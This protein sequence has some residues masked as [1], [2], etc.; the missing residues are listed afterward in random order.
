MWPLLLVLAALGAGPESLPGP[1]RGVPREALL[2]IGE[3]GRDGVALGRELWVWDLGTGKKRI[4]AK[5][6]AEKWQSISLAPRTDGEVERALLVAPRRLLVVH[7]RTGRAIADWRVSGDGQRFAFWSPD[8]RKIGLVGWD[9]PALR[10]PPRRADEIPVLIIDAEV[11][12]VVSELRLP[13]AATLSGATFLRDSRT[14]VV[15]VGS[16]L[17][18]LGPGPSDARTIAIEH[19]RVIGATRDAIVVQR[20]GTFVL[21]DPASGAR[22]S[23]QG[24]V[25]APVELSGEARMLPGGRW[26]YVA[27]R[28]A[29][30]AC[31]LGRREVTPLDIATLGG[32]VF[33][34]TDGFVVVGKK[35]TRVDSTGGLPEAWRALRLC[36]R[37]T[38][39]SGDGAMVDL[40]HNRVYSGDFKRGEPEGQGMLR[41][42][43]GSVYVGTFARGKPHGPGRLISASGSERQVRAVEGEWATP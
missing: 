5:L 2:A 9:L 40:V 28:E 31:D 10:T 22:A 42:E 29:V 3:D 38:C 7:L 34:S 39:L 8:G 41:Y 21:V 4:S 30:F 36:S 1:P 6:P 32:E 43:D 25:R 37:G 18:V 26:V 13:V 11:G 27:G 14:I 33:P 23:N 15:G 17:V 12:S 16:R 24:V 35:V 20:R 19:E